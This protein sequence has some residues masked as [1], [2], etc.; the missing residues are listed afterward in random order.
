MAIGGVINT[1]NHPK[2]LWPGVKAWWGKAYDDHQV[3]YTDLF[4]TVSSDKAYEEDVQ[5]VGFGLAQVKAQ[6]AGVTYDSEI[7]GFTT[8]YT[9]VAYAL[10][11]IVTHE[12]LKDN[13]YSEVS[14]TR[15]ASL[16]RGFRQT[17]ERV[18]ANVYNRAF[19]SSY[20]GGDGVSLLNAAHPNTSGGT[21]SNVLAVAA[22]FSEASLEDLTIQ[23]MKATDDRGLLINLMPQSL[24]V[25]PDNFYNAHRI[26]GS[27]YQPGNANNDINVVKAMNVLPKGI[28]VNHY[29]TD[30][31]AWFVRTNVAN[32]LKYYEREAISFDQDNDFDTMNAKAKGYERYSFGWTDPRALYG[33]PGA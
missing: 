7:Q 18:G 25:A 8:R 10:G 13:L 29:F 14:N 31:D 2:A 22:D 16:A 23:I 9:H 1:S 11:Y 12:E 17:K 33:S 20:T 26:L 32:G 28:K 24:H 4:E 21:F 15:A 19:N 27:V 5:L 30:A 3:E 6:G